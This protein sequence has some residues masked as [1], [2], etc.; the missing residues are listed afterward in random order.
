MDDQHLRVLSREPDKIAGE[1]PGRRWQQVTSCW[2]P[3][4]VD[5][6][7]PGRKERTS[8]TLRSHPTPLKPLQPATSRGWDSSVA[9]QRGKYWNP[10]RW[11]DGCLLDCLMSHPRTHRSSLPCCDSEKREQ[12]SSRHDLKHNISI[13]RGVGGL[14]LRPDETSDDVPRAREFSDHLSGLHIP[15]SCAIVPASRAQLLPI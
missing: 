9:R 14:Q 8:H 11:I 5:K 3:D 15:D 1:E 6:N 7:F 4:S 12:K 13:K 2:C 10:V